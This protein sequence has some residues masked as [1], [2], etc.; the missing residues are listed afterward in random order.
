[1]IWRGLL[2]D[3]VMQAGYGY[4]ELVRLL[5]EAGVPATLIG[6]ADDRITDELIEIILQR[7][8]RSPEQSKRYVKCLMQACRKMNDLLR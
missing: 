5:T 2:T 3:S 8:R 4:R 6:E 7:F 1:M